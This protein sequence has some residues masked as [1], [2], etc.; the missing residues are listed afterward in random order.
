MV[1]G[2][3]WYDSDEVAAALQCMA[4]AVHGDSSAGTR[5]AE[6][7]EGKWQAAAAAAAAGKH[8]MA[9]ALGPSQVNE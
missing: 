7:V 2:E 6:E 8:E 9:R 1:R 5:A 3:E 4:T